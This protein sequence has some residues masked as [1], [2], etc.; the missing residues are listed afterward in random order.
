MSHFLKRAIGQSLPRAPHPG[1]SS[2]PIFLEHR[3]HHI[4]MIREDPCSLGSDLALTGRNLSCRRAGENILH[5]CPAGAK[6]LWANR[7]AARPYLGQDAIDRVELVHAEFVTLRSPG[8]R[9]GD[10]GPEPI[11]KTGFGPVPENTQH[12]GGTPRAAGPGGIPRR[13]LGT[14]KGLCACSRSAGV[15]PVHIVLRTSAKDM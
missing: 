3:P 11:E 4:L 7:H 1:D 2:T 14:R 10:R 9:S 8:R 15:S 6:V 13:S 12:H 5:E